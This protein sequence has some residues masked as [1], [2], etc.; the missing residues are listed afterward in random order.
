MEGR[1]TPGVGGLRVPTP[2]H[3]VWNSMAA[4]KWVAPLGSGWE[5]VWKGG[6]CW[7]GGWLGACYAEGITEA[8]MLEEEVD[9]WKAC[10]YQ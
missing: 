8:G 3:W 1:T 9:W 7:V 5:A 2:S 4:C 10:L 6:C